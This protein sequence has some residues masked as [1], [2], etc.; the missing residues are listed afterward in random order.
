[1]PNI[2]LS[3]LG[4]IVLVVV[5]GGTL[6]LIQRSYFRSGND[7]EK[8]T[9]VME[10]SMKKLLVASIQLAE[11]GGTVVKQIR[12][13]HQLNE[14]SKGKTKEGA[15]NPVTDGDMKSHEAIIS[16]FSK[17]FPTVYVSLG[18]LYFI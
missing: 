8:A 2:K 11:R 5:G 9:G 15:N 16:G 3:P 17:S 1:M 4:V 12:D 14:K 7:V 13:E 18:H 10:I 6:L